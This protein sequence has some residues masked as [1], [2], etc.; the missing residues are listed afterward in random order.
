[1]QLRVIHGSSLLFS[2]MRTAAECSLSIINVSSIHPFGCIHTSH[3]TRE[4]FK[5]RLKNWLFE[6]A[7]GWRASDRRWLKASRIN[8]WTYQLTYIHA[9][10]KSILT[11]VGRWMYH[12]S[13]LLPCCMEPCCYT[14]GCCGNW[15]T[16]ALD[17]TNGI[18][19]CTKLVGLHA[20]I[21]PILLSNHIPC[22][23]SLANIHITSI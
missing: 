9:A 10:R 23:V 11:L 22:E 12:V 21:M 7:Y 4:Q 13:N 1:V 19:V 15:Q 8:P 5:R 20:K 16:L 3:S 18:L 6:S 2:T 14:G 17:C